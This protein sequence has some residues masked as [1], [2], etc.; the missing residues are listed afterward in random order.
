[1]T[2]QGIAIALGKSLVLNQEALAMVKARYNALEASTGLTR[3][4]RKMATLPEG[5]DPLPN[6]VGTAPGVTIKVGA[7]RL[8]W[9]PGVRS[10]MKAIF[11]GSV[12]RMLR[13]SKAQ[14]PE[15]GS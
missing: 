4:R 12:I 14:A 15:E 11:T 8:V 2:L 3:F 13:G 5:A 9:L 10:V 6:P 1:M 7:T